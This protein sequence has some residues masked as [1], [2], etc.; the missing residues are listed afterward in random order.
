MLGRYQNPFEEQVRTMAKAAAARD[1]ASGREPKWDKKPKTEKQK[2]HRKK[3]LAGAA[4]AISMVCLFNYVAA[5]RTMEPWIVLNRQEFTVEDV[6][7]ERIMSVGFEICSYKGESV[8]TTCFVPWIGPAGDLYILKDSQRYHLSKELEKKG[9]IKAVSKAKANTDYVMGLHFYETERSGNRLITYAWLADGYLSDENS[10]AVLIDAASRPVIIEAT[11]DG[12][13]FSAV[14]VWEVKTEDDMKRLPA[15][16]RHS[17]DEES[18]LD[19]EIKR[20][21]LLDLQATR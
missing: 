16:V 13:G 3:L 14:S 11:E 21:T 10:D 20:D 19:A 17:L 18:R 1:R 5:S 2:R 6:E 7:M 9:N 4:A 12:H 15:S 8:D